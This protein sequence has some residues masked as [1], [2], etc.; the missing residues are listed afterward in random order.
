MLARPTYSTPKPGHLDRQHN[1]KVLRRVNEC[2][3]VV[4]QLEG[5][6]VDL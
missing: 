5:V 2:V 4:S 3:F 1:V 6:A